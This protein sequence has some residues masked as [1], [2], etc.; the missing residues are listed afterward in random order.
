MHE[1]AEGR[2]HGCIFWVHS[3]RPELLATRQFKKKK[4]TVTSE[5]VSES[6]GFDARLAVFPGDL[7]RLVP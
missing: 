6:R 4:K 1:D 3:E 7:N 5:A 2:T